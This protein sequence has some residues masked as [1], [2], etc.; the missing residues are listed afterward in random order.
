MVLAH[1][2][3]AQV[4]D[5]F[6]EDLEDREDWEDWEDWDVARKVAQEV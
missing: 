6:R 2:R 3:M 4:R 5:V 1:T